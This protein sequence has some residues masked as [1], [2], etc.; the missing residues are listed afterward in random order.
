MAHS[1]WFLGVIFGLV[2]LSSAVSLLFVH[3]YER[4]DSTVRLVD[5]GRVCQSRDIAKPMDR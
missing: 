3:D 5:E 1:G 2:S 4:V